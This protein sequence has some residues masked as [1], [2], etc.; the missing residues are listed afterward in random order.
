MNYRT[1]RDV[2]LLGN[3]IL[4]VAKKNFPLQIAHSQPEVAMKDLGM[5]ICTCDLEEA[6]SVSVKFGHNQAMIH[7][8]DDSD[9]YRDGIV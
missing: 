8:G 4:S 3:A 9:A 6:L 7:S 2:L 5:K 1:T